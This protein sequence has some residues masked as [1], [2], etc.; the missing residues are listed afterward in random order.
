MDGLSSGNPVLMALLGV[1]GGSVGVE[2]VR[3]YFARGSKRLEDG[4]LMREKLWARVSDLENQIRDMQREHRLDIERLEKAADEWQQRYMETAAKLQ[5]VLL[6]VETLRAR[7]N[8]G[9]GAPG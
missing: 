8:T 7:V 3:G 4:A 6:E 9:A 2:A 1:V 5:V